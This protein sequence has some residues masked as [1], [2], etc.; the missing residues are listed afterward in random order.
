VVNAWLA[1][2]FDEAG[3][4]AGNVAAINQ[5]DKKYR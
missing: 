1:S 4:S 3:P 5:L 2:D